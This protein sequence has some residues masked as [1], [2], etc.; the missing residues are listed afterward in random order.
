MLLSR[1]VI[2]V[3][4]LPATFTDMTPREKWIFAPLIAMT[5]ILGVYPRLVTDITGPSVEALLVN[6][7]DALPT[8]AAASDDLAQAAVSH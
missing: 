8:E 1:G 6:F 2:A 3:G 4:D 5:L 7:H